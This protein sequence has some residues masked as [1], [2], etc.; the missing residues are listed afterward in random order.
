MHPVQPGHALVI[1]KKHTDYI[2]DIND[3]EYCELMLNVKM[4]AVLLK[5]KMNSKKV[6]IIVEGFG[7]SHGHVHLIPINGLG[8]LNTDKARM[9]AD[10]EELRNLANKILNG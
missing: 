8:E 9:D 2:F 4:V 1:P 3:E 6:G 10:I 5:S 7:V